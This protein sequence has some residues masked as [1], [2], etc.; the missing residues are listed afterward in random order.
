M[1]GVASLGGA[2]LLGACGRPQ[3]ILNAETDVTTTVNELAINGPADGN[4][5]P[6]VRLNPPEKQTRPCQPRYS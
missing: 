4:L 3:E 5:V 1:G 2:V 6:A